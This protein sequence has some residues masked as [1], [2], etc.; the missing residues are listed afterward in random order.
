MASFE[1]RAT[2]MPKL[3]TLPLPGE[4]TPTVPLTFQLKCLLA[5]IACQ[6]DRVLE[7]DLFGVIFPD[8]GRANLVHRVFQVAAAGPNQ[9]PALLLSETNQSAGCNSEEPLVL[10]RQS[11]AAYPFIS[12]FMRAVDSHSHISV[13][14]R[15]GGRCI[16][17][18]VACSRNPGFYSTERIPQMAAVAVEVAGLVAEITCSFP[19]SQALH[20]LKW[21]ALLDLNNQLIASRRLAEY[22]PIVAR[23]LREALP[24]ADFG[25]LGMRRRG[26][27]SVH[28]RIYSPE[29][30]EAGLVVSEEALTGECDHGWAIQHQAP[31]F[32]DD[33]REGPTRGSQANGATEELGVIAACFIPLLCEGECFG[34]IGVMSREHAAFRNVDRAW[35]LKAAD[36]IALSIR[37]GLAYGELRATARKMQAENQYLAEERDFG[38][39]NHRGI[40]I[41]SPGFRAAMEQARIVA[42][43]NATVL[44]LGETGTGKE[45]IARAIHEWS[46]RA[47]RALVKLNCAAIPTGLLES[48]LFG[49]EKGAF[50]GAVTRKIGRMEVA[51]EG[52]LFLDEVGD[53]PSEIQPKLLRALQE[54]DFERLGSTKTQHVDVRLIAATNR[55]LVE[56]V[57]NREFRADLFYRLNV[58]PIRV[59]PLRERLE[60]IEPLTHRFMDRYSREMG[61]KVTH[62]PEATLKAL[63]AW[64]WPGNVRELENLVERAVILSKGSTL[65]IPLGELGADVQR[66]SAAPTLEQAEREHIERVLS[67]T[68]GVIAGPQGAAKKLGLKRT[69]LQYK[70]K[71]LGIGRRSTT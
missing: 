13:P 18:L 37:N 12:D 6:L 42:E 47:T 67:E 23:F 61:K 38:E 24:Q 52:T 68:G 46:R 2:T 17:R 50:T 54:N 15:R 60:S 36:Q 31:L 57:A 5:Q 3:V 56:M 4:R 10:T 43:T 64:R 8:A 55:N 41:T 35:L 44:I 11:A 22:G 65:E 58:F 33:I 45:L 19:G 1:F 40:V 25:S 71:K 34:A 27:D 26:E 39:P 20:D 30:G 29:S 21:E 70:I 48:E 16:A 69:T 28:V 32:L 59:P 9:S 62:L 7:S 53:I 66:G 14:V 49:H 63:R 51:H